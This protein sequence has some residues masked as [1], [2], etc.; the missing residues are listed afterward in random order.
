MTDGNTHDDISSQI[1]DEETGN[2]KG[3][4]EKAK[5]SLASEIRF[6]VLFFIG[7]ILF[8]T[9]GWQHYRIP[10]ESMQPTLEVGDRLYVS[11]F[12]YGYS[13][14]DLPFGGKMDFLG[15]WVINASLPERGDVAVFRNPHFDRVLIKRVVG[16]PGDV[17][18]Y[19]SGRLY[20]NGELIERKFMDEFSYRRHEP[21]GAIETVKQY[22]ESWPGEEGSHF[23]YEATDNG[24]FDNAGEY[25]V[26]AGHIFLTG[27]NRDNSTDSRIGLVAH[28]PYNS[29][30]GFVPLSHLIGRAERM[31]LSFNRCEDEPGL[32]CPPS[33][34][35]QKL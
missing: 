17:I 32:H 23:I 5:P 25:I 26:P 22:E 7:F 8:S 6:Y 1:G 24:N 30:P 31:V 18:E 21:K 9:F 16:L 28:D 34:W 13:R 19:R 35:F 29:G 10:S 27:D 12:A 14:H 15:D 11:K 2:K 20:I 3:K 33:R 4:A